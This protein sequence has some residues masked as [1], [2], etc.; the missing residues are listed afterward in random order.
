MTDGTARGVGLS[1]VAALDPP[2]LSGWGQ[3]GV[4]ARERLDEDLVRLTERAVLSRGLGR[5][6]G[7]SALP[8][9]SCDEVAGTRL[10]D[11]ILAFDPGTGRIR[12]EAGVSIGTL[13]W[14][15]LP[16]GF[17][18]PVT[19]GTQFVT[20]G[21]AVA[22]DV[23]GKNHHVAGCFGAHV[24]E[25][26]IRVADGR[27][28]DCSRTR[29]PDLFRATLGGMGLTGHVLEVAFRMERVPSGWVFHEAERIDDVETFVARLE[30]AAAAWP[31]TMG[32]VDCATRG[33]GLGRG[34]LQRG[35]WADPTE[36]PPSPPSPLPERVVP[37]SMPNWAINRL[38]T[39]IFNELY[40][41]KQI[42]RST[43]GIVHPERF[44][45]PLDALRHWY[46]LYG[47]RGFTQY[48]CVLPKP[49]APVKA[50][51]FL[52]LLTSR[53]GASPLCVI[54]DCGP[55]GEGILSFP[56]EGI[57]IAVDLWIDDRTQSL[58]D[59]LNEYVIDAGG[60]IYLTKD[61]LTRP[62]H[63]RAMEPRLPEFEAVRR[64]WDP[65]LTIRSH[66]SVRLFGDPP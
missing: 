30:E 37:F 1:P 54:K 28:V 36:A 49:N 9:P 4:R 41:R 55:Q 64:A 62:E 13:V 8:P 58:V 53:G 65:D 44:F 47:P 34:I 26:R 60:R 21:G 59:A 40:Y 16:R 18:P 27:I 17:F 61:A 12:V 11:R 3:L 42:P 22:S 10:A 5:S 35:R 7:D 19:P 14:T 15:F 57:S 29:H 25:L 23:H 31:M 63:F 45:Y 43:W 38:T 56:M 52:E 6:Y 20:V 48:Q 24:D 39:R 50:R 33:R 66:Q 51:R 32:W 2:R 46:R